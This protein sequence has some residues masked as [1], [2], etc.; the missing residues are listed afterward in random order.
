MA[1]KNK[2]EGME[3][4]DGERAGDIMIAIDSLTTIISLCDGMLRR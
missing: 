2:D 1:V 4:K 3:E